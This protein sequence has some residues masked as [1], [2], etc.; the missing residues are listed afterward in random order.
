MNP[1]QQI[2]QINS[3]FKIQDGLQFDQCSNGSQNSVDKFTAKNSP[4]FNNRI[5][6]DYDKILKIE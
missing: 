1:D 2:N 3:I 6:L 5:N 4:N